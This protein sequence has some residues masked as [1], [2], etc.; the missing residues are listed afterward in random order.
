[1]QIFVFLLQYI[2]GGCMIDYLSNPAWIEP[3]I[4][5]LLFLQNFRVGY[6]EFLDK[7]FLSVTVFGEFWLPTIICAIV[8]WCFDF[9]AGIYLFSLESFNIFLTHFFKMIACVYRP[10]VLD[11]RIQPSSL[12]IPYAKGYSFPSGHSAMS[13]SVVGGVAFIQRRNV[14]L[15]VSLIFLVLLIGFSRLWLGVHTPQDVI[16]GLLTGLILIFVINSLIN[17]AEQNKD[18]YLFLMPVINILAII[19]L[20]YVVFFNSYRTDYLD[21]GELLVDPQKL[22]YVTIIA[23]S[24]ALGSINGCFLCRRFYPFEPKKLSVKTRITRGIIGYVCVIL[25]FKFI[26]EYI[27]MN[28]IDFKI[29]IPSM[30]LVGMTVT[31]FMPII[32]SKLKI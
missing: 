9:K 17:W 21:S 3:Q 7:F 23:Y 8:Y 2:C 14:K 22:K 19:A 27:F 6:F 1:M 11:S 18:R 31:L 13:S 12:A 16:C 29:A 32:F 30:F 10:W 28:I 4:N 26:L 15:C 24:Y 20:L 5:F 25:L